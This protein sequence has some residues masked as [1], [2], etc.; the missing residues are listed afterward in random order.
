MVPA[1]LT[2][3]SVGLRPVT[4][5]IAAGWRSDPPVSVPSE[6]N[7]RR[8]ATAAAEPLDEPPGTCARCHGLWQWP[9]CSL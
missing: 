9:K 6:P 1:P 4:P 3:V 5:H 7:T 2:R 8:A